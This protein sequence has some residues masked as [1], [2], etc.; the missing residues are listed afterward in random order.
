MSNCQRLFFFVRKSFVYCHRKSISF[1]NFLTRVYWPP[2]QSSR[3]FRQLNSFFVS[4]SLRSKTVSHQCLLSHCCWDSRRPPTP[5]TLLPSKT[6]APVLSRLLVNPSAEDA[7]HL[8]ELSLI[9]YN[10]LFLAAPW[11][12]NFASQITCL[13]R[14]LFTQ[15]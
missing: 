1:I 5:H 4:V 2:K 7:F 3:G 6:V 15:R 9:C 10:P 8:Q 13:A 12:D 11:A 14:A